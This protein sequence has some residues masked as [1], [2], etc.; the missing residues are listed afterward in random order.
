MPSISIVIPIYNVEFYLPQCIDSV[1]SQSF[2]DIEI[3]CVDDG[4]T[5]RSGAIA[6]FYAA[7]DSRV[8]VLSLDNKGVSHAR[9]VGLDSATGDYVCFVDADDILLPK[10]CETVCSTFERE[11]V[12]IVKFSAEPF[13][14]CLASP[15]IRDNLLLDDKLYNSYSDDLV[16]IEHS[17][18]FPW[19]GAYRRSFLVQ[20]GIRFPEGVSLGEDQVFSFATLSRANGTAMLSDCLYR[21]RVSRKDSAMAR[22]SKSLSD[23]VQKHLR[24]VELILDDWKAAG[25]MNGESARRILTFVADFITPNIIELTDDADRDALLVDFRDILVRRFTMQEISSWLNGDR[26]L[27]WIERI[28]TYDGDFRPFKG[29]ALYSFVAS[30]SGYKE[31]LTRLRSVFLEKLL[32]FV[33]RNRVADAT[34]SAA[35]ECALLRDDVEAMRAVQMFAIEFYGRSID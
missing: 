17:R 22:A 31:S 24:V 32:K 11:G 20:N 9:N 26:V 2:S 33:R 10:A 14:A 8:K 18:P 30:V 29:M 3:I 16:F 7:L 28:Y 34:Y 21:Y 12:D 35:A 5:D 6:S 23:R 25:R 1:R 13:P 4:S 19:N 15:W 27:K